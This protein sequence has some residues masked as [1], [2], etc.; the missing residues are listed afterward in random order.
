[1]RICLVSP[2][3]PP[4]PCGGIG[5]YAQVWSRLLA[6]AGHEVHLVTKQWKDEPEY[7][8]QDSI[9][10]H[11]VVPRNAATG[12]NA[13]E[14]PDK[15]AIEMI[16]VR[17]YTGLLSLAYADKLRWL[18]GEHPMDIIEGAENEAPLYF[19]QTR[20]IVERGFPQTPVVTYVH[21]PYGECQRY[22]EDMLHDPRTR[23][24]VHLEDFCMSAADGIVVSS[25]AMGDWVRR[26][27][28]VAEETLLTCHYPTALQIPPELPREN[29]PS[30]GSPRVILYVGRLERR[31]GVDNLVRAV[32]PLLRE[33]PDLQ[34]H[35]CG[36]DTDFAP[37]GTGM[38]EV[39][40]RIAPPE[41]HDR[42]VFLGEVRHDQLAQK[43]RDAA[44]V[45]LPSR[46]EPYGFTCQEAMSQG[47]LVA[48]TRGTGFDEMI[49]DGVS[50]LTF[51]P[52]DIPA[53]RGT[54]RRA[55][56]LPPEERLRLRAGAHQAML[57]RLSSEEILAR[58]IGH[59]ERTIER[60]RSCKRASKPFPSNLPFSEHPLREPHPKASAPPLP[61]R[62]KLSVI[63]P[64]Y[65][66]GEFLAE[67]I[68]SCLK[69]TRRP[70]EILIVDDGSTD[71]ATVEEIDRW[72]RRHP[73]LIRVVRTENMGLPTARNTGA[74]AASGDVF[75][76]LDADDWLGEE[77]FERALYVLQTHPEVGAVTA[78]ADSFGI[79]NTMWAPPHASFPDLFA[80]CPSAPPA[81]V[82]ADAYREAGGTSPDSAYAYEDW[83]LWLSLCGKGWIMAMLPAGHIHYRMR[84]GS[85][86]RSYRPATVA[87][88][89]R[90]L[91]EHHAELFRRY[92]ADAAL[93][94]D[95]RPAPG[96]TPAGQAELE[97]NYR[98]LEAEVFTLREMV[99]RYRS[100]P[101]HPL[102]T[103]RWA[104]SRARA[105]LLAKK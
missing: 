97:E 47:A 12:R 14:D 35:F 22:N 38:L 39:L 73:D 91:A 67:A 2:E 36:R 17:H 20:Q 95:F 45:C 59:Y 86:S 74:A 78:W 15:I 34:V 4:C 43:Y 37:R 92:A 7:E 25:R 85:M 65:N 24:R 71:P 1:M 90:V 16:H 33:Q 26:R 8:Q 103:L 82:R 28:G 13:F 60:A 5:T 56:A 30:P 11:R 101:R 87:H 105:R 89:R 21:G 48:A 46:W 66:L 80:E 99:H 79:F 57:N 68:E 96:Q 3:L 52:D 29:T 61:P 18:L 50:G 32:V 9:H 51:P 6:S 75:C 42:L 100:I 64:T 104:M 76:F 81:V 102:R 84:P 58:R 93:L 10:I 62:P 19:F 94:C 83:D 63:V 27:F 41:L 53:I 98:R 72:G 44:V 70:D 49:E 69:Q 23:Y 54:L 77:Y 88:G 31:K 40:R 55:L